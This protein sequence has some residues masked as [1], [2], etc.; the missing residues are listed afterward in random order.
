MLR[1]DEETSSSKGSQ[2]NSSEIVR[3]S[4]GIVWGEILSD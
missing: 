3:V 4:D 2:E 1:S